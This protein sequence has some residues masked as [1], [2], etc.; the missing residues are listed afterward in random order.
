MQKS[1][2]ASEI[3]SMSKP[4][5]A[6][7]I[8]RRLQAEAI[9]NTIGKTVTATQDLDEV[10]TTVIQIIN[11]K[12]QVETGSVLLREP[13]SDELVFVKILR[14]AAE[15]LSPIRLRMGQGIAGWVAATGTSA[16]VP[17]TSTD[18]RW[19]AGVDRQTGFATR[20]II[21]V[22]LAVKDQVIGVIELLNKKD[23]NFNDD[24]LNLLESIAAPVAI[25]IQNARL[26][27]Q[28]QGQL[29]QVSAL[30]SKVALAKKEW[31]QTVDAIDEGISLQDKQASIL[32]A[33][34]TL[35]AWV[36]ATPTELVGQPCYHIVHGRATPPDYCPHS[37]VVA[38]PAQTA[39]TEFYEA[40]LK[41]N[42][43]CTVYPFLAA[44]GVLAGAVNVL[45]DVT[46]EKELQSQLIQS[47]KM[48][49]VGQLTASL[50]HEINN[51]LQAIQGCIDLARMKADDRTQQDKFLGIAQNELQRL[52]A[53]VQRMLDFN[54]PA[55]TE[56]QWLDLR[57]L[58]NDVLALSAKQLEHA[59]I[60]VHQ[61]WQSEIPPIKGASNHL[62]QVIL[63]L[64]L[65]AIDSMPGGGKLTICGKMQIPDAQWLTL[66]INDSG[67]GIAADDLPK[68]F[69]PFY[70]TKAH[71]TGLGLPIC[72]TIMDNHNGRLTVTSE[73]GVGSTFTVWLPV[74][75]GKECQ[76]KNES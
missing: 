17:D 37:R 4:K 41:R 66:E 1:V 19:F 39:T 14:G 62:K 46:R 33:N 22:P 67:T 65:N 25:A 71:G 36:N 73:Y 32:R 15:M 9:W 72:R 8:R 35:A 60:I 29:E 24:D 6:Q 51:P 52:K 38:Q 75:R 23:G 40:R 56:W 16:I 3:T 31:E 20:S 11:E 44:D 26:H 13:G 7:E 76:S 2:I 43:Q 28:I 70:T 18:A 42:F 30:F 27:R 50:A 49:A 64:V 48:A 68:I 69:K 55:E 58:V 21:C 74:G 10:L 34:T 63:N 5:L 47:E 45:K 53:V 61:E 12:L 54:R 59:G 57:E